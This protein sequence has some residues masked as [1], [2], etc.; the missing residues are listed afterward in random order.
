MGDTLWM[1]AS[2]H[3]CQME[4]AAFS[5]TKWDRCLLEG[6]RLRESQWIHVRLLRTRFSQCDL[7]QAQWDHTPLEGMDVTTCQIGGWRISPFD[8]KGLQVRP[9]QALELSSLLGLTIVEE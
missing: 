4:Y 1:N 5:D 9:T 8:I 6:C 2:L 3:H 7:L